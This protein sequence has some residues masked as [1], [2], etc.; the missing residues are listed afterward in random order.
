MRFLNYSIPFFTSPRD[1]LTT[2][3]VSS[4]ITNIL[5]ISVPRSLYFIAITIVIIIIITIIFIIIIISVIY[6]HYYYLCYY[7]YSYLLISSIFGMANDLKFGPT[8]CQ[9]SNESTARI[10]A[11]QQNIS[12]EEFCSE[13]GRYRLGHEYSALMELVTFNPPLTEL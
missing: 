12:A 10:Y 11:A 3:I 13:V 8:E 5:L 4:V 6:Y 9:V 7:Y 1:P 2:G